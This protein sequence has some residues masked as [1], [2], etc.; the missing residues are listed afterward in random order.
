[1]TQTT[2]YNVQVGDRVSLL[3][4]NAGRELTDIQGEVVGV[5]ADY[6]NPDL[7]SVLIAGI[8]AWIFLG[9]NTE[10]GGL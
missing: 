3:I 10:I 5:R 8:D 9:D 4:R 6:L 2:K 1:M 7:K